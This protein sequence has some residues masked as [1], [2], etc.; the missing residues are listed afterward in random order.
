[1]KSIIQEQRLIDLTL[2]PG[3]IT[4]KVTLEV[5]SGHIIEKVARNNHGFTTGESFL[6]NLIG[7]CDKKAVCGQEE[8]LNVVDL[9]FCKI[10]DTVF[11][12]YCTQVR[13]LQ[14]DRL[15]CYRWSATC[16]RE[17]CRCLSSESG[18]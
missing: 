14:L 2:V 9:N 5:I 7:F 3:K 4:K 15:E 13:I 8:I 16:L 17:V 10:L 18:G 12:Y 11:Q 6:S 1:M